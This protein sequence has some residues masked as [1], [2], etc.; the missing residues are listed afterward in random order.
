MKECKWINKLFAVLLLLSA[1]A[2]VFRG[3]VL[4]K[5]INP[6]NGLYT[7]DTTGAVFFAVLLVILAV[8]AVL[9]FPLKKWELAVPKK[10]GVFAKSVSGLCAVILV[11]VGI[12]TIISF[13]SAGFSVLRLVEAIFCLLSAVFFV[14]NTTGAKAFTKGI[15]EMFP[16]LYIA[17]HTIIIFID[18][19]TQINASQRSFNLLFLVCLMMYFVTEAGLY[20]PAKEEES[21]IENSKS[22]AQSKIWALLSAELALMIALSGVVFDVATGDMTA[23]VYGIAHICLAAYALTK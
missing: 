18:T 16:A 15:F 7:N 12:M 3:F 19:T 14:I 4:F 6:T 10:N 1:A 8:T 2:G 22:A 13:S 9:Y 5:Y 20:I 21:A 23:V 11:V 17:I